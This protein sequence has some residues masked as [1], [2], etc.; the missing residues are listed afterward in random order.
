M[1]Y[2]NRK[3]MTFW[4]DLDSMSFFFDPTMVKRGNENLVPQKR[5]KN[6]YFGP[7]LAFFHLF[8]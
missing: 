4:A 5:P 8:C 2:L 1:A 3:Y 6:G 7:F